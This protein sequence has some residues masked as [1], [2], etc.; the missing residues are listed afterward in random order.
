M[1]P[2]LPWQAGPAAGSSPWGDGSSPLGGGS[3]A[4]QHEMCLTCLQPGLQWAHPSTLL[5]FLLLLPAGSPWVATEQ[6]GHAAVHLLV[7]VPSALS[8]RSQ[9]WQIGGRS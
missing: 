6:H 8:G 5:L 3:R 4:G 9:G 2:G 1:L 7:M